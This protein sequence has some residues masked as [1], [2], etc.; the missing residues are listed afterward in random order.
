LLVGYF[1]WSSMIRDLLSHD[2]DA[3]AFDVTRSPLENL[4]GARAAPPDVLVID[5]PPEE[6]AVAAEICGVARK[7]ADRSA[8]VV[9]ARRPDFG[10]IASALDAGAD[11]YVLEAPR[12]GPELGARLRLAIWRRNA[13]RVQGVG[14]T[15]GVGT[16]RLDLVTREATLAGRPLDLTTHQWLLLVCMLS[17]PGRPVSPAV[18]CTFAGIQADSE[19]R[20]LHTEIWRLR[21]KLPNSAGAVVRSIRKQGYGVFAASE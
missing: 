3:W 18:L 2:E 13:S 11:D 9:H 17:E 12:S 7:H 14:R 21:R 5:D 6:P 4:K 8:I 20:N 1:D 15:L 16:L 10:R 19:F